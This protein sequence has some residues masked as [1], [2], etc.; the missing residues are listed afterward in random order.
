M[1]PRLQRY[2]DCAV[3]HGD[4]STRSSKVANAA[5]KKLMTVF[6]KL[7]AA[8]E[9]HLLF[10]LYSDPEPAVQAWAAA[11][12]LELDETRAMEKLREL[13]E[14]NVPVASSRAAKSRVSSVSRPIRPH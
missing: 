14:C 9:D 7:V 8:K 12:T 5:V 11:Q 1:D 6:R 2:R 3:I 4:I 10:E 13:E